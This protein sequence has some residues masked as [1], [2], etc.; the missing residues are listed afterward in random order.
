MNYEIKLRKEAAEVARRL[1]S[2]DEYYL[3]NIFRLSNIG[4]N[5]YDQCWDTEFHTFGL[6]ASETDHL[7]LQHV[8]QHCSKEMLKK[9]DVEI[10]ETITHYKDMVN[11]ACNEVITKH[12]H[13]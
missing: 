11:S 6:I 12:E 2:S 10:A 9:V 1:L 8:R 13:V 5:L 3:D 4:S 7:P